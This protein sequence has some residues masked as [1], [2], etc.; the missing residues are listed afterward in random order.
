MSDADVSF[1][2]ESGTLTEDS[3]LTKLHIDAHLLRDSIAAN[4]EG[5]VEIEDVTYKDVSTAV[6][7]LVTCLLSQH[8]P[9]I[10]AE[11]MINQYTATV[12]DA[13]STLGQ[14]L[15]HAAV[16]AVSKGLPIKPYITLLAEIKRCQSLLDREKARLSLRWPLILRIATIQSQKVDTSL[17]ERISLIKVGFTRFSRTL[18]RPRQA[19]V[20]KWYKTKTILKRLIDL[21]EGLVEA[22]R[23]IVDSE[24]T[25]LAL[26][27][28]Y[29]ESV[30]DVSRPWVAKKPS[31]FIHLLPRYLEPKTTWFD[32]YGTAQAVLDFSTTGVTLETKIV[33]DQH[34]I[35]PAPGASTSTSS[36]PRAP[37]VFNRIPSNVVALSPAAQDLGQVGQTSI[38]E[39]LHSIS[40]H[41]LYK[42]S[43]FEVCD[44]I[45]R[46]HVALTN[47]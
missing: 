31:I 38:R 1:E 4:A 40:A 19:L 25:S 8:H 16:G 15:E 22:L 11:A 39:R 30:L 5:E 42:R 45:W 33:D 21:S 26:R 32:A 20:I 37:N 47:S 27:K 44:S 13:Y 36:Q 43:F 7:M 12:V 9:A 34:A 28:A 6:D 17:Y 23:E 24:D 46:I 35:P 14:I 29:E 41:D 10:V 18:L 3:S 2:V